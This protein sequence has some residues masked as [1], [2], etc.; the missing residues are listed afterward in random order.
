MNRDRVSVVLTTYQRP[1]LAKQALDSI[2]DQT[3]EPAEV[4]V[5]EDAGESDLAN[6]ISALGRN[7]VTHVCHEANR[8]LAASRN[9]G[10]HLAKYELIAYLDDDDRWLPARLQEQIERYQSLPPYQRQKL[11]AIQV[12]CEIVDDR[13]KI[14]YQVLP[15]NQGNL[16]DSIIALGAATPSSSFMFVRSALLDIGGFDEGLVSGIDH[17]I[18]MKLAVA[19]YSNEIIRK[20]LVVVTRDDR[21]TMM[22][23]T[24]HRIAGISRFVEKWT[25]TYREWFGERGGE[26]YARRYFI[27]VVGGLAGQNFARR[28]FRDGTYATRSALRR[29]G[30]RPTLLVLLINRLLSTYLALAIPQLGTAKRALLGRRGV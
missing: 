1:E 7:N 6:W 30:W 24:N 13:G 12:G 10:L 3:L 5:V 17:D 20:P 23:T 9:T 2:F 11:A 21:T 25:P 22:S 18:W 8:G 27:N 14:K 4:I 16:R 28:R 15:V 19:G 26:I 29:V